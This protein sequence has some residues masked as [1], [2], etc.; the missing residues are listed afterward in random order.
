MLRWYVG[1]RL[2]LLLLLLWWLLL[3]LR[4]VLL[5]V[6][7]TILGEP[8]LLAVTRLLVLAV[9]LLPVLLV[10]VVLLLAISILLVL[11]SG[12]ER[13]RAG[14]KALCPGYEAVGLP[15]AILKI[16][17]LLR[18]LAEVVRLILPRVRHPR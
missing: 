9:A 10:A 14:L 3:M 2:L 17:A 12:L 5:T 13:V 15:A 11:L 4:V 6:L 1:L 18:L 7:L 16:Q 8:T